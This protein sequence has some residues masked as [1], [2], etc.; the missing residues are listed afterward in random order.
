MHRSLCICGLLPRLTTRTR[1]VVVIHQLETNKPTNTGVVAARCLQNSAVVYRGRGPED[2][3]GGDLGALAAAA[4]RSVVLFPHPAAT[5]LAD[6]RGTDGLQLIVPDGT[7]SQAART[8]RRLEVLAGLPCVALPARAAGP[9]R[10]RAAPRPGRLATLEALA[11]A[12]GVLE[13]SEIEDALM[14]VYR[15]MTQRTLWT[16][17]RIRTEDVAGGIPPGVQSHDPLGARR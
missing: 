8:R 3:P 15:V 2:A 17:G 5:P 12:L 9:D 4:P 10:L 16:N 1:V 7:W 13:G 11:V 6:W 14:R